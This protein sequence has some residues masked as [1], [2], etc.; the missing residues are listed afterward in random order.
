MSETLIKLKFKG[1]RREY[2]RNPMD[3]PIQEGD[4]LI[5]ENDKGMDLGAVT[6]V[7]RGYQPQTGIS[8]Y[9]IIRKANEHDREMLRKNR[10]DEKSIKAQTREKICELG[11]VMKLM[12]VEYQLD[13][14]KLSFYYTADE[15]VDFRE[16]VRV[17]AGMFRTRIEMRQ[18]GVR[19]E[20][21]RL[22]GI[23]VCGMPLCCGAF[24]ENF[25]PVSTQIAKD[26]SLPMNPLKLSGQCGKLKCCLLYEH[27]FYQEEL[28]KYPPVGEALLKD[29][30]KGY[31]QKIDI[32]NQM[33]TCGFE[34]DSVELIPLEA[35]MDYLTAAQKKG[36]KK[37]TNVL[38]DLLETDVHALEKIEDK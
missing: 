24:L 19:D 25:D 4:L 9:E 18:I 2:F 3:F 32:F 11:L 35:I 29:Q 38:Q 27:G 30:R 7:T 16:L 10:E 26:Q 21:K 13:R 33:V 15:R 23:G 34:D 20:T 37:L 22:G 28:R 14:K 31:I 8:A 36:L 6:A 5:V 1:N 17:L 12:D